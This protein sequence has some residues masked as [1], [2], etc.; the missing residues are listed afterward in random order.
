MSGEPKRVDQP[1]AAEQIE[2]LKQAA[3]MPGA[4]VVGISEQLTGLSRQLSGAAGD[5]AEAVA[6]QSAAV[7]VLRGADPPPLGPEY[8]TVLAEAFDTLFSRLRMLAA[9]MV[10]RRRPGRRSR[11]TARQESLRQLMSSGS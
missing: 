1:S 5:A 11:P 4:D 10:P 9:R 2:A 7:D 8:L 6:A 3:G